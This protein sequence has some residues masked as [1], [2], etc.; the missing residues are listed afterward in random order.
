VSALRD[1]RGRGYLDGQNLSIDVRWLLDENPHFATE[2][3]R[4][5]DRP[6]RGMGQPAAIAASLATAQ[7]K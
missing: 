5:D 3:V 6:Y 7:S 1:E 4:S 2:L